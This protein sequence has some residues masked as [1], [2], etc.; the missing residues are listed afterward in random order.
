MG[1]ETDEEATRRGN[2]D[3]AWLVLMH[4]QLLEPDKLARIRWRDLTE[5]KDGS[6]RLWL[7]DAA[8][9]LINQDNGGH[10]VPPSVMEK[11][12]AI[13]PDPPQLDARIMPLSTCALRHRIKRACKDAGLVGNYT[14]L[15]CRNGMMLDLAERGY[16][17]LEIMN[18][19]RLRRPD[20]VYICAGEELVAHGAVADFTDRS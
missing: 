14:G 10:I 3:I 17:P 13:R 19:A 7:R 6:G 5:M 11:L 8:D 20:R 1:M 4:C 9:E 16:S 18:A 2:C 12:A 15:S